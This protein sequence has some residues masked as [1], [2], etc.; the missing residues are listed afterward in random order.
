M[1]G[2]KNKYVNDLGKL[3]CGSSFLGVFPSDVQ[4]KFKNKS[5]KFS[6]IFNT[7]KHDRQG[8]HLVAIFRDKD[9]L[10]YFDSFGKKCNLKL[11][12]Q[13]I[14]KNLRVS[15]YIY[16]KKPIQDNESL[17]CGLFCIAFINSL[18]KNIDY[19]IFLN[20]FSNKNLKLNNDI[21]IQMIKDE[22]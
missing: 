2:L 17:F 7:D 20:K 13:F 18:N 10:Y 5:C 15:K 4:P 1:P 14:K 8:S 3:I 21:V 12:K 22:F 9:K 11:L 19:N 16:N 6:V